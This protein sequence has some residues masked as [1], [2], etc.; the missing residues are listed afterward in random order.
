[1]TRLHT[2]L[3]N[4]FANRLIQANLTNNFERLVEINEIIFHVAENFEFFDKKFNKKL[5]YDYIDMIAYGTPL[6]PKSYYK[7]LK[8]G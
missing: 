4:T 8:D 1:M 6:K 3:A 2:K 7:T 5:W